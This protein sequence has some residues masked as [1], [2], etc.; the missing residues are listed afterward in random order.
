[1]KIEERIREAITHRV[2][3]VRPAEGAWDS[4]SRRVEG[5]GGRSRVQRALV[6]VFALAIAAVTTVAL[7]V[8]FRGVG[9]RLPVGGEPTASS[10]STSPVQE[11]TVCFESRAKG[12]FDGD[13][14]ADTAILHA[15]VPGTVK[16][17]GPVV[18]LAWRWELTVERA[19]GAVTVQ[20]FDD[21]LAI[22]IE[23]QIQGTYDFGGEG[24]PELAVTVGPGASVSFTQVYRVENDRVIPIELDPPGDPEVSLKPGPILLGG[25]TDAIGQSGFYCEVRGDGSRTL[26]AWQATRNDGASPWNIHL[27]TL[28]LRGD[29]FAVVA[30]EDRNNVTALPSDQE[31][32]R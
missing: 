23:C 14:M 28:V 19:S 25:P 31:S 10:L 6:A 30:I 22:S 1:M 8:S 20:S 3:R 9:S 24:R 5:Q 17:G 27:T 18:D 21:C 11:Q 29:T 15:L 26:I 32:C 12:D 2:S 4:I 16:C 7:W 13:G